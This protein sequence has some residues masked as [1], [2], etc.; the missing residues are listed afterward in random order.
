MHITQC[1]HNAQLIRELKIILLLLNMVY[2]LYFADWLN[3][4][5]DCQCCEMSC[6]Q[7]LI[8]AVVKIPLLTSKR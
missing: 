1:I 8:Y 7:Y 2:F 3:L 4:V 5:A 6:G